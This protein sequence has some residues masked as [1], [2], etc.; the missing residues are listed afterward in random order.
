[1][2]QDKERLEDLARSEKAMIQ[3]YT[4]AVLESGSPKLQQ[5][6]V[7][8]LNGAVQSLSLVTGE[9]ETRGWSTSIVADGGS[10][11]NLLT[12]YQGEQTQLAQEM[13]QAQGQL[14]QQGAPQ[15]E[16]QA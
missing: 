10:V 16:I 14:M 5:D 4:Q 12:K 6:L 13:T 8:L 7:S 9:M 1:M 15:T 2:W 3:L 11:Q